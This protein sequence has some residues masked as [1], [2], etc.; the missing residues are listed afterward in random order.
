M[1]SGGTGVWWDR[2]LVGPASRRSSGPDRRDA[3]PTGS[4]SPTGLVYEEGSTLDGEEGGHVMTRPDRNVRP[5][6]PDAAFVAACRM[7][8]A[9]FA[10]AFALAVR[11]EVAR[12]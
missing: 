8:D 12:R 6:Q 9:S 11:D 5:A 3:G 7:P 10:A 2:R 4:D 1:L